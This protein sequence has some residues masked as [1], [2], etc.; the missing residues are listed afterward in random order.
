MLKWQRSNQM[1]AT[2]QDPSTFV[3]VSA[4]PRLAA[5][6]SDGSHVF[7]ILADRFAALATGF[8]RL[9]GSEFVSGALLMRRATTHA[10]D[11]SLFVAVHCG[12]AAR[13]S[14]RHEVLL[15]PAIVSDAR[16]P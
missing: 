5:F 11:L 8:A 9:F 12:E 15:N 7:T 2:C 13:S 4:S 16:D 3:L 14:L 6:T 10:S 1:R